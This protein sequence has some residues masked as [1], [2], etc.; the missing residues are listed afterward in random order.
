M[1][2]T[3]DDWRK[4][5]FSDESTFHILK[6]KNQCKICRLEKK[7]LLECILQIDTGSGGKVGISAFGTTATKIYTEN[8]NG[9]L[10]C[11][12]LQHQLKS[13]MTKKKSNLFQQ[14]L[15]RWRASNI[16]KEKIA[17]LKL[18]VLDCA[19]KR[20][21]LNPMKMLWSIRD[22]KLASKTIHSTA[23]SID[24]FQEERYNID[25][26]SWIKL[27]ASMSKRIQKCSKTKGEQFL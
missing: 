26:D 19:P 14:D 21:D 13:Q 22:E 17:N 2:W 1:H 18:D 16:A 3:V 24:R 7:K 27:I 5:I 11:D 9:K 15:A 23:A 10:Y 6:R 25:Q 12:V 8:M 4:F 20:P